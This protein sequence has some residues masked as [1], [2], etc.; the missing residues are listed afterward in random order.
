L[1]LQLFNEDTLRERKSLT[2]WRR[3]SP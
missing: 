2:T 3:G 1:V